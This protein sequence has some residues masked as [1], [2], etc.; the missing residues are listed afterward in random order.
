M[1]T[2]KNMEK[3]LENLKSNPYFEK[4][5]S[6]I[7]ELQKTS[8]EEF[9]ERVEQQHKNKEEEKKKKFASVEMRLVKNLCF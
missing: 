2:S 7:A 3:A 8:P 6:R 1:T 4:Y 9:I 5:A